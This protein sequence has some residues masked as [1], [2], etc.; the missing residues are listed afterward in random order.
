MTP[1]IRITIMLNIVTLLF[2]YA[3][4]AHALECYSNLDCSTLCLSP[5]KGICLKEPFESQ[6]KCICIN[7]TS[8]QIT[9]DDK[10]E[11]EKLLDQI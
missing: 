10:K 8:E 5:E 2:L 7:N 3:T 4:F 1:L 6:G 9:E 11:L